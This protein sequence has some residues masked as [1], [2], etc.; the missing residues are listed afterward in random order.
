MFDILCII[1]L[2]FI[3]DRKFGE[4]KNKLHPTAWVGSIILKLVNI[5]INYNKYEKFLGI[6][7]TISVV[8]IVLS[9]LYTIMGLVTLLA[10]YTALDYVFYAFLIIFISMLLKTTISI[11]GMEKHAILIMD[12]LDNNNYNDA[13]KK[14]SL[15][16]SRNTIKLDKNHI[17]SGVLESMSEN[18]V[19]GI[20]GPLF[21]FMLFGI[22]AA[23]VYRTINTIDSMIGYKNTTFKNIGWFGANCDTFLNYLPS[24]LTA[25]VII[26]CALIL[27]YNWR[28]S[29]KIMKRD[30]MKTESYNSGYPMAAL[31]GALQVKL[32]KIDHYIIGDG[33]INL[34]TKIIKSAIQ[35]MKLT[36][37]VFCSILIVC[38]LLLFYYMGWMFYV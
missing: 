11:N 15:I 23:F 33:S 6:A 37:I 20:T 30:N 29:I 18:T 14:L 1:I 38:E 12:A 13:R 22:K 27:G 17:I 26:L 9:V 24:R 21:Y 8:I 3:I 32:E 16:V 4:P 19:D 5:I 35:I 36:P 34:T 10:N 2:T 25:Y 28:N 31:A 7:L